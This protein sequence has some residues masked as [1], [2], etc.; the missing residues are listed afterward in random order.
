MKHLNKFIPVY[1]FLAIFGQMVLTG[2]EGAELFGV[3]SP[4]WL[5]EKVDSIANANNSSSGDEE[6]LEGQMEDVYTF[7]STDYSSGFWT[8]FS[9]YYV[10]PENTKWQSVFTLHINPSSS[11]LYYQNFGLVIT[12]DYDRGDGSYKEYG[13]IRFDTTGDSATYNSQWGSSYYYLPFK[14]STSNLLLSPES[15][16]DTNIQ[17]MGGQITLTVDRSVVDTFTVRITNGTVTK[18]YQQPYSLPS[19]ND[20]ATDMDIRCFLV[21][22]GSYIDFVSTNIEPIGGCTSAEDKN[23]VSMVLENVPE[24]VGLGT[25]LDSLVSGITA[26]VTFEEGVTASVTS[27]DLTF[28]AVPDMTTAGEKTLVAVYNKTYKGENADTPITATASFEVVEQVEALEV[29]SQPTR[30]TYYYYTSAAT[31]SMTG[32]T[33]A[34]DTTGLEVTATYSSGKTEVIDNSRLTFGTVPASVGSHAVTISSGDVTTTATVNVAESPV[35]TVTSS[36]AEVGTA[37]CATGWWTAFSEDFNV[38]SGETK[39]ISFTNYSS[40][41]DNWNNFVVILRNA[42]L[43]EYAVVRADNFGWGNGYAAC[44]LSGGQSDWA[45]WLADMKGSKVT[46]YVTNCGNGTADVQAVMT[47]VSG[48][49]YIQYYLGINTVDPADFNFAFTV[50]SSY[51]VFD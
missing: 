25:E 2:C 43:A 39:S 20:D 3:D 32:R 48:T 16:I 4:D 49:T 5:S 26:T 38:P 19:L 37:D 46:V 9:K 18:V 27:A 29:T 47:G 24:Y 28:T 6:E 41:D 33:M 35:S 45:T 11:T 44:T 15:N 13:V 36:L 1:L 51:I 17:S 42:A 30:S 8:A 12:N 50:D 21:P 14:Y 23:P 10:V 22:E 34:F 31:Q 7:G 40:L